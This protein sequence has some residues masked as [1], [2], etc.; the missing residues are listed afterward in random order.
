M[1]ALA[2]LNDVAPSGHAGLRCRTAAAAA[3]GRRCRGECRDGCL[4]HRVG[5][6]Q[7]LRLAGGIMGMVGH[8]SESSQKL[9]VLVNMADRAQLRLCC[10][11]RHASREGVGLVVEGGA[12]AVLLA[13]AHQREFLQLCKQCRAVVCCRVSPIQ[14]VLASSERLLWWL[15]QLQIQHHGFFRANGVEC[16]AGK[17]CEPGQSRW[18]HRAVHWRR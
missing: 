15:R 1:I 8:S 4:Q 7:S 5:T 9:A 18:T 2:C 11:W 12:L 6:L 16:H 14:K 3:A 17:G 10:P 13:E